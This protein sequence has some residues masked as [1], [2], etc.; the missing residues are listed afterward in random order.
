MGLHQNPSFTHFV[1]LN[2]QNLPERVHLPAH[3][4]EHLVNGV[5]L[6]FAL[7]EPVESEADRHVLSRFHKQRRRFSLFLSGLAR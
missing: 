4:L 7:L 5:D 6:D 1:F 2:F 3:V